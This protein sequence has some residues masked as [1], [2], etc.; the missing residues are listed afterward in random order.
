MSK[1][2]AL[3]MLK[4]G[5]SSPELKL[6]GTPVPQI[7]SGE[8]LVK[9]RASPI[10]PADILNSK[11]GFPTTVFPR[12][13]GKDFAG[14]VV[15]GPEEW[16]GKDV[17]GTSGDSFGFTDDGAHAEYTVLKESA[18]AMMPKNLSFAQA[19]SLGT[20]FT[21]ANMCLLRASLKPSDAVMVIGATGSVGSSVM[22]IAKAHGSKT[23]GVGRHGTDINS[24]EDP[25]LTRAMDMTDGKGVDVVVDTVGDFA[26]V[27]AAIKVMNIGGRFAFIT[28]PRQSSTELPVDILSLYRRQI[29]LIGCNSA[30]Q[31]QAAMTKMLR[32]LASEFET[33]KLQA[34]NEKDLNLIQL[35]QAI[36]AYSG[37]IKKAVIVFD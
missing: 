6:V 35:D 33:G 14:T 15:E 22:Q 30:A 28:A 9:I 21:T 1:M 10:L 18:V 26:L 2:K 36:D 17:F 13:P 23:I 34:P 8:V 25:E 16:K 24:S 19:A 29:S 20:P 5:S 12:I 7:T 32:E 27:R 4:E 3:R 31:T 11:G 37:K